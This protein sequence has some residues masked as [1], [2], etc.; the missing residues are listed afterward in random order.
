VRQRS[1]TVKSEKCLEPV[2]TAVLS[3]ARQRK[4]HLSETAAVDIQRETDHIPTETIHQR[5]SIPNLLNEDGYVKTAD[6]F[7]NYPDSLSES[8][9]ESSDV[10]VQTTSPAVQGVPTTILPSGSSI[11]LT[12]SSSEES[13]YH[14][15]GLVK[16]HRI[17]SD[18]F[19]TQV[20]D[21]V[22]NVESSEL[23]YEEFF[24]KVKVLVDL[25]DDYTCINDWGHHEYE[26]VKQKTE[27]FSDE[28]YIE[29]VVSDFNQFPNIKDPNLS[30]LPPTNSTSSYS[31]SKL[32]RSLPSLIDKS[33]PKG[34]TSDSKCTEDKDGYTVIKPTSS[35][36]NLLND[37]Q[38]GCTQPPLPPRRK[39][40]S[41]SPNTL[42]NRMLQQTLG[43][44]LPEVP[45]RPCHTFSNSDLLTKH[46]PPRV[47]RRSP[48]SDKAEDSVSSSPS[49][50]FVGNSSP[51]PPPPRVYSHSHS[52]DINTTPKPFTP[53]V[54]P[55]SLQLAPTSTQTK[56]GLTSSTSED[57]FMNVADVLREHRMLQNHLYKSRMATEMNSEVVG[58]SMTSPVS[59][60][61]SSLCSPQDSI[62]MPYTK[63]L[64]TVN[65]RGS[66]HRSLSLTSL[67]SSDG[68]RG[69]AKQ[70]AVIG[71]VEPLY[72]APLNAG[73]RSL[74]LG[75]AQPTVQSAT[76]E[77]WLQPGTTGKNKKV[78]WKRKLYCCL[79]AGELFMYTSKRHQLQHL[80]PHRV[81]KLSGF[82]QLAKLSDDEIRMCTLE[83]TV[84]LKADNKLECTN[85][86]AAL[87]QMMESAEV[88][89]CESRG[90]A[91]VEGSLTAVVHGTSYKC[92][93][94]LE[95]GQL[96]LYNSSEKERL[97]F[98][99][100][101]QN[102]KV[103]LDSTN[104]S[105]E[106][107][108]PKADSPK[109]SCAPICLKEEDGIAVRLLVEACCH[110]KWHF[111]L[112]GESTPSA[113]RH[114]PLHSSHSGS[115]V[116]CLTHKSV[117]VPF[118][119]LPTQALI[120]LAKTMFE[121]IQTYTSTSIENTSEKELWYFVVY[122]Q[123]LLEKCM[124]HQEL[125]GEFY[126]QLISLISQ[127][128]SENKLKT[129][130]GWQLMAI[131]IPLFLP[132]NPRQIWHMEKFIHKNLKCR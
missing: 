120:S 50:S 69:L 105:T 76:Y 124:V 11:S 99:F 28:Q 1:I 39:R 27:R 102:Y 71:Y 29:I 85:W 23:T 36:F 19:C 75:N 112:S 67:N 113:L 2:A 126:S 96:L 92:F 10:N 119:F 79:E 118:T 82:C 116:E 125:Q 73:Y 48:L 51:P 13:D 55:S 6:C 83:E 59:F 80:K 57:D 14:E 56:V 54:A 5:C 131:A 98:T 94:S 46:T 16:P 74:Q 49:I 20:Q 63:Q 58:K 86:V 89:H 106:R 26:H 42:P 43:R 78:S 38:Q 41:D 70:S 90:S 117:E 68:C 123:S 77:G 88:P 17:S 34:S 111:F 4:H 15:I 18:D 32:S 53:A 31:E 33:A 65:S 84:H 8:E 115:D 7:I 129:L 91:I 24:A 101:L 3:Q 114:N 104:S 97:L 30:F 25:V 45:P 44:D 9:S 107:S 64:S 60:G 61:P 72:A 35:T 95:T 108:S 100:T 47:Q 127:H 110:Q 109:E 66:L 81:L 128:N 40:S 62:T 122:L 121:Q 52:W 22:Q 132:N 21:L 37:P 130:Q 12:P 103:V 93:G 87:S